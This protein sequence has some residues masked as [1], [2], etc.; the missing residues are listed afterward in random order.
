MALEYFFCCYAFH[1]S[2]N[3]INKIGWNTFNQK[4][5]MIFFISDRKKDL[6]ALLYPQTDIC[7]DELKVEID[8]ILNIGLLAENQAL[9]TVL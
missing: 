7:S 8:R 9:G 5:N 6:I 3:L 4:M 2:D 1:N